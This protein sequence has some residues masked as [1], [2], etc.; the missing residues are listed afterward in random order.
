M[1]ALRSVFGDHEV[2]EKT[3]RQLFIAPPS[4]YELDIDLLYTVTLK[5]TDSRLEPFQGFS[6]GSPPYA[7]SET[8]KQSRLR[9]PVTSLSI[10]LS[11]FGL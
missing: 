1:K 6:I 4:N 5:A 11:A 8:A 10:W 9:L 7:P 3:A 2:N